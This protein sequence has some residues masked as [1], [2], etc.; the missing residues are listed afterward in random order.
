MRVVCLQLE[1]HMNKA[2]KTDKASAEYEKELMKQKERAMAESDSE[3]DD[4]E[5]KRRRREEKKRLK[6]EKDLGGGEKK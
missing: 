1:R 5:R 4:Q 2:F 6:E 3:E